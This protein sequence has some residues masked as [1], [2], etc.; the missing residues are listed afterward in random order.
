MSQ[1]R[2]GMRVP[3]TEITFQTPQ[4]NM[5]QIAQTIR[6]STVQWPQ[7]DFEDG[8]SNDPSFNEATPT[9]DGLY[10]ETGAG[11]RAQGGLR[12][13][14]DSC[15]TDP[16]ARAIPPPTAAF[17]TSPTRARPDERG[18][19]QIQG[20]TQN[21]LKRLE[22]LANRAKPLTAF[23]AIRSMSKATNKT[24]ASRLA[25]TQVGPTKA[26]LSP[27]REQPPH[28]PQQPWLMHRTSA[29]REKRHSS[30]VYATV[31]AKSM[32]S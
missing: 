10:I 30:T 9:I 1:T 4:K 12:E 3:E 27:T 18:S 22:E 17:T 6:P 2:A 13:A 7:K 15:M 8:V 25:S 21:R 29:T 11:A 19:S 31:F 26:L 16:E 5:Q 24:S 23:G 14:R 28:L 20:F 32:S